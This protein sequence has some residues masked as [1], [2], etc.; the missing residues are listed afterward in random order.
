MQT[1]LQVSEASTPRPEIPDLE[2][3]GH[4]AH[5]HY[6]PVKDRISGASAY[7]AGAFGVRAA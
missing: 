2:K 7:C 4:M 1:T 6:V 3:P 5:G